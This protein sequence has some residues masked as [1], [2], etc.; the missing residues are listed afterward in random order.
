MLP[1]FCVRAMLALGACYATCGKAWTA[2]YAAAGLVAGTITA[3]AL[4]PVSA[5][6]CNGLE[7]TCM[8]ACTSAS[9][10]AFNASVVV[11]ALAAMYQKHR[12]AQRLDANK[13]SR[14]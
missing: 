6:T 10:M 4:A 9:G 3:G 14:L 1:V 7:S 12:T 11:T 5:L 2:C 8:V 13:H